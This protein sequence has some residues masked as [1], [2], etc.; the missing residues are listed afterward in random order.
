MSVAVQD[1]AVLR[2]QPGIVSVS[3]KNGTVT[4]K[5]DSVRVLSKGIV[6][7]ELYEF[8]PVPRG[9]APPPSS[10][11]MASYAADQTFPARGVRIA[12]R[13]LP[14]NALVDHLPSRQAVMAEARRCERIIAAV[15]RGEFPAKVGPWC[16]SCLY[17]FECPR[18]FDGE[19]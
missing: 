15:A 14:D 11:L 2:A 5:A 4:M 7:A 10:V 3:L 18:D 13:Y 17:L 1:T 8:R 6:E 16:S 19:E 9:N 12:V